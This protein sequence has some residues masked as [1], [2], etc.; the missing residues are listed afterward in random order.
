M[1]AWLFQIFFICLHNQLS[2]IYSI[3]M[4]QENR[5]LKNVVHQ[6]VSKNVWLLLSASFTAKVGLIFVL[7]LENVRGLILKPTER[8]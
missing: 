5:C 4:Y 6:I 7:T 2:S 1:A 8:A 3:N